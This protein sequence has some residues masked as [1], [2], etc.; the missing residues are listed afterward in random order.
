M[1][2]YLLVD[3]GTGNTRVALTDSSGKILALR[4]FTNVYYTDN[5]YPDAHYFLPQEW[6]EL[7]LKYCDEIHNEL[8]DVKI[9]AV[10]SA[11]ARETI[12]LL[13]RSGKA[14]LGL[15]NIDNR[16]R[17]YMHKIDG[18]DDIYRISG[19]WATEDFCAAKLLGYKKL[20][21]A[22][23]EKTGSILSLD[24][25]IGRIFTGLLT[26]EPSQAC[27]TSLYD[28]GE[29]RWSKE[30][31][32]IF[33]IDYSILP[34]LVSAG[35]VTGPVNSEF[36]KRLGMSDNAVFVEGGADTQAALHQTGIQKG[37]VAIVS[38]TTSPVVTLVD[39]KYYDPCQRVW[40]DVNFG[41]DGYVVEMNPG[42]TGLNYQ[43]IK[44]NLCPDISYEELE[45]AYDEKAEFHCTASFSSLLFYEQRSL[46]KG[47]FFM[48]SPLTDKVDRIDMAW[49]VIA[50]IA[51][52]VYE[53]L[54][55]LAELTGFEKKYILGC[56]GGFRSAALC[57]MI[58]D[59][60]GFELRIRPGFEQAT[61]NGLVELC[62]NALGYDN[63]YVST[64]YISYFPRKQQ[65]IH[66]YH[67]VWNANRMDANR[68]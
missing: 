44:S 8:P 9:D 23:F 60:S 51:C 52:S 58:A 53:Q 48:Q 1:K 65:L 62:N 64:E 18:K 55:R 12:V 22:D 16:G 43:R 39:H 5:A 38:G 25:W 3:L 33:G 50:D 42:V 54:Y 59:L 46:R 40:T 13:D 35:T 49:A 19:K 26:F 41:G 47:G 17:E 63:N 2:H 66:K 67:P 29:N 14:F 15:P 6:E 57:Q 61:V 28:I 10:S 20:Y 56:G 45:K 27:E 68:I 7:I 31:C 21:P 11:A 4:T 37:D 30:L 36:I 32:G 24:G 34:S